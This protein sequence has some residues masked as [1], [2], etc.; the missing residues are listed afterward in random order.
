M[1]IVDNP[2]ADSLFQANIKLA[3]CIRELQTAVGV[4]IEDLKAGC[5]REAIV[6]ALQDALDGN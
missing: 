6:E 3:I 5:P 1:H 2:Q 4:A